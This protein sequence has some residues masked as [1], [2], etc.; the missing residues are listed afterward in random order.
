MTVQEEDSKMNLPTVSNLI[1]SLA[2][3]VFSCLTWKATRSYSRL[4]GLALLLTHF[5]RLLTLPNEAPR[6]A[7]LEAMKIIRG[8]FP[9][10]YERMKNRINENDRREIEGPDYS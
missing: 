4:T 5:E 8:E 3:V 9:D 10:I 1:L 2:V 6:K 7:S